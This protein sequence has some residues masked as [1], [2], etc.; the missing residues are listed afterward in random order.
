M[1][2]RSKIN[3]VEDPVVEAE[4][5]PPEPPPE[6]LPEITRDDPGVPFPQWDRPCAYVCQAQQDDSGLTAAIAFTTGVAISTL[7]QV[8]FSNRL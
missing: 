7:F 8:L 4:P 2:F 5:P 6:P 3:T 1:T